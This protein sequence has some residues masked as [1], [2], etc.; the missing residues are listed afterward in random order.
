MNFVNFNDLPDTARVWIF[1]AENP[2]D[3]SQVQKLTENMRL[4]LEQ[5][6]AHKS[7]LNPSWE[8][9]HVPQQDPQY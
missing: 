8:L 3:S 2:L 6:T 9:R 7:E 5:W 4:F 1:C